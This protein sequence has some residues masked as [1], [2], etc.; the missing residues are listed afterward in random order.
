[1]NWI[2]KKLRAAT[3]LTPLNPSDLKEASFYIVTV[4]TPIDA[5]QSAGPKT[6]ACCYANYWQSAE[7]G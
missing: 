7:E 2:Q 6:I 3:S 4:P 5:P 1:M